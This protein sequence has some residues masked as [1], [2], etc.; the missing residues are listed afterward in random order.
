MTAE[1]RKMGIT[2]EELPDG[3]VIT[4]GKLK[5]CKN[6]Q[7]YK[8][9]RIAMS[10]AIAAMTAKGESIIHNAECISVTYPEFIRDFRQTGAVFSE[11]YD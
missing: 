7:S 5:C 2:V 3:M 4:G 8:D 11:L 6:L 9:H 1:L 10:L